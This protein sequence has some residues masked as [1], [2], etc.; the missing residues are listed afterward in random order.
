MTHVPRPLPDA[1]IELVSYR[2]QLLGQPLR[3]RVLDHLES[4]G[5]INVQ[6]LADAVGGTQQNVSRALGLLAGAGVV[7]RRPEG[8]I[9]WYRVADPQ[10][11]FV[12][13]GTAARVVEQL[14]QV[15]R[16][17]DR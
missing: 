14:H 9:V 13:H 6:D 2:L 16:G 1:L 8:R 10:A 12:I 5:V 17:D 3:I 4:H 15:E 11:F 7:T